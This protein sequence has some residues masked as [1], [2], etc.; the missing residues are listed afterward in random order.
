MKP[1]KNINYLKKEILEL[2]KELRNLKQNGKNPIG[3]NIEI[4]NKQT[5]D[6]KLTELNNISN[7]LCFM[8]HT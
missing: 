3:K 8:L 5:E 6:S 4:S 2:A 7:S 1:K